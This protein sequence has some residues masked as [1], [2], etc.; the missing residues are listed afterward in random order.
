M[1]EI[2]GENASAGPA[3]EIPI[4][5]PTLYEYYFDTEKLKWIHWAQKFLNMIIKLAVS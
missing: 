1:T 4:H 3:G 2:P 5:Y